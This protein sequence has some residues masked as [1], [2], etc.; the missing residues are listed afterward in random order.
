MYSN[1]GNVMTSGQRLR[2]VIEAKGCVS[3]KGAWDLEP[4]AD[5]KERCKESSCRESKDICISRTSFSLP[6]PPTEGVQRGKAP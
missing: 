2:D 5:L 1:R 4:E 3:Q 6:M